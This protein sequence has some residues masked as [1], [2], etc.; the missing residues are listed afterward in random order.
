MKSHGLLKFL[1]IIFSVASE[2]TL[3]AQAQATQASVPPTPKATELALPLPSQVKKTVVFVHASCLHDFKQD[4]TQ[5]NSDFLRTLSP[6]QIAN[7]ANQLRAI[8]T[9]LWE[10]PV[11][12]AKLNVD[13]I[14]TLNSPQPDIVAMLSAVVKMT[15]LSGAELDGL[16]AEQLLLLPVDSSDGTAFLVG[17]PE[18]RLPKNQHFQYLVTNRHVAEAF[19]ADGKPCTLVNLEVLL[20]KKVVAGQNVSRLNTVSLGRHVRW[21]FPTDDSVDLAA[22]SFTPPESEYDI[23]SIPLDMFVTDEMLQTKQ[24]VEG[25]PVLFCGLF[26]QTFREV[27]RLEPILRAGVLAMVPDG[28]METTLKKQGSVLL[29]DAHVYGG[30]SGS[31]VL[32]DINRFSQTFGSNFL[33]LGVVAGELYENSDLTLTVTSTARGSVNGNSGVSQIVPA[34]EVK[35][36]LETPELQNQREAA[37]K[38]QVSGKP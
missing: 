18:P 12:K 4:A 13:E 35:K 20:N 14:Q 1:L 28:S 34:F 17:Y 8:L 10:I 29:A 37:I 31:P 30:N 2:P 36:L 15:N 3:T 26:I 23:L 33:F 6:Q 21:I 19:L 24:V 32:V 11:A 16:S 9:K 25:D 5:I 7:I 38:R 22:I 27:H